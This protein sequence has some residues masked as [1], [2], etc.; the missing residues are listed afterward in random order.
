MAQYSL[1]SLLKGNFSLVSIMINQLE[2]KEY[3]F[4]FDIVT[5]Y[6]CQSD[7]KDWYKIAS[8]LVNSSSA[9]FAKSCQHR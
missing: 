3:F 2:E 4:S 5:S 1:N 9:L 8:K 6:F 7:L